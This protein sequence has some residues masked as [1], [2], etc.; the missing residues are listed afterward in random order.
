MAGFKGYKR[1]IVLDFE[2]KSVKDGTQEVNKQMALL[3]AEFRRASEQAKATGTSFDILTINQEK[4]QKQM[5][6]QADK[7]AILKRELED[8]TRAEGNNEKAITRKTIELKNAQTALIKTSSQLKRVNNELDKNNNSLGSISTSVKDFKSNADQMNVSLEDTIHKLQGIA[9]ATTAAIGGIVKLGMDFDESF[10]KVKTIADD[11]Q[12]SFEDLRKQ[13][14]DMSRDMKLAHV[15]ANDLADGLYEIVSAN[16]STADS[17]KVL[18]ESAKLAETGFTDMKTSTDIMTTILNAYKLS[19]Q[20]ASYITDQLITIQKLGKTTIDELGNDFGR[21]AGLA[22]TANVP[23]E[24]MG[25]AIAVLTTNGIKSSESIT[26]LKAI[27]GAVVNPTKEAAETARELGINFNIAT[28]RS[29][30]LARFLKEVEAN[31]RGNDE[32]MA[33]LFGS[34]EALN[35]MFILASKDG[36]KQFNDNAS[37]IT[38]STGAADAAMANL[39][40]TGTRFKDSW[41]NLKTT[42]IE[43]SDA[44]AP[45]VDFISMLITGLSKV[46]PAIIIAVGTG[47]LVAKVLATISS[48]LPVL[49]ATSSMAAGGLTSLGVAGGL[50]S[51]QILLIAGAVALVV[52]LLAMLSGS[53][54]KAEQDMRSL[55]NTANEVVSKTQSSARQ[56]AQ[57]ISRRSYAIGTQYHQ[58]GRALVGEYGPEEVILPVGSKVLT[59]SETARNN[60]ERGNTYT[61]TGPI[62]V[63]ANNVKDFLEELQIAVRRGAFN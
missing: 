58:G 49:A 46:N 38:N 3:N 23:L 36:I 31:T 34:V 56:A 9:V 32:A 29:K 48:I 47:M 25:A 26:A 35:A 37:K 6:L 53:S 41:N 4:L 18:E 22:A 33:K 24:E 10:N 54:K 45:L 39:D 21:V 27:L 16:I 5:K 17:M 57:N 1:S 42:L 28:L 30:G 60:V 63:Q 11:T 20:D 44:F 2:Y 50:S 13:T 62:H 12:I 8:I 40:G 52:G 14:L 43:C 51:G 19:V 15:T 59:A 61:F 7:V 55:G